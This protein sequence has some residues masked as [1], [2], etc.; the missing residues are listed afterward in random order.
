MGKVWFLGLG[1][2]PTVPFHPLPFPPL[3]LVATILLIFLRVN[4]PNFVQFKTV[5]RQN[6]VH[7]Q[8]FGVGG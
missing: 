8:G 4:L 7:D 2:N 6:I 1:A 3:L 5:L